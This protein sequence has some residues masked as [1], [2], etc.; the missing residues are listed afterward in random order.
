MA[1]EG[2]GANWIL[3]KS[4]AGWSARAIFKPYCHGKPVEHP[5]DILWD[6]QGGLNI[7][8]ENE[9]WKKHL[10]PALNGPT[11]ILS[12]L[13]KLATD[14]DPAGSEV[15]CKHFLCTWDESLVLVAHGSPNGSYGYFYFAVC[16]MRKEDAPAEK[17]TS[18]EE[19]RV[20]QIAWER[21][22]RERDR[23][24]AA[25]RKIQSANTRARNKVLREK[26]AERFKGMVFRDPGQELEVGDGVCI[27]VNQSTRQALVR[28]VVEGEAL[29]EYWMPNGKSF[30]RIIRVDNHGLVRTVARMS[31]VPKRFRQSA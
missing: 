26:A 20:R 3:E 7:G 8:D 14:F 17:Q 2:F 13:Q 16:L 18:G 29:V 22:R 1:G 27:D 25:D 30:L 31:D 9:L 5:L 21:E 15:L 11:G 19:S 24:E 6:R 28:A 10:Q 23:Q 4:L 12:Q